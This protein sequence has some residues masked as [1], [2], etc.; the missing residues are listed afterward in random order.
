MCIKNKEVNAI[1]KRQKKMVILLLFICL[2]LFVVFKDCIPKIFVFND[3]FSMPVGLYLIDRDDDYKV[4]DIVVVD[5]P[6]QIK[7]FMIT[8]GYLKEGNDLIKKIE[9]IEGDVYH[10]KNQSAYINAKYLGQIY[11][12]D[13]NKRPVPQFL[14]EHVIPKDYF[15]AIADNRPNSFDSR[16][17]GFLEL[18]DIKYKVHPLL[19]FK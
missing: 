13:S 18:K 6:Q 9:G 17:F 8:R 12:V 16:Y 10:T 7:N 4:G 15:L 3:S 1:N 14:G 19:T 2:S 11:K 5:P